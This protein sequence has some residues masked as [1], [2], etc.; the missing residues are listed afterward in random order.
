MLSRLRSPRNE[1][2]LSYKPLDTF[3]RW[4]RKGNCHSFSPLSTSAQH[5]TRKQTG[6]KTYGKSPYVDREQTVLMT[7]QSVLQRMTSLT[8]KLNVGFGMSRINSDADI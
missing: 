1:P 7:S 8:T 3:S 4:L 2:K 6:N 5:E